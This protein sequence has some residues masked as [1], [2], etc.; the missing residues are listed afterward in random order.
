MWCLASIFPDKTRRGARKCSYP[1]RS[2]ACAKKFKCV[3]WAN[4]SSCTETSNSWKETQIFIKRMCKVRQ[5][6]KGSEYRHDKS[7]SEV[8]PVQRVLTLSD[9]ATALTNFGSQVKHITAQVE[10]LQAN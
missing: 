10:Q 4:F 1:A 3:R 9:F 8:L 5:I 7:H 2:Q 6:N